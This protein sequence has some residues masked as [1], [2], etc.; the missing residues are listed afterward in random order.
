MR[1]ARRAVNQGPFRAP[2]HRR[3]VVCSTTAGRSEDRRARRLLQDP[4]EPRTGIASP[5]AMPVVGLFR[6]GACNATRRRVRSADSGSIERRVEPQH[7]HDGGHLLLASLDEVDG[8]AD[9]GVPLLLELPD[10]ELAV[11]PVATPAVP[12]ELDPR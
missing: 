7:A 5:H 1:Q 8:E 12:R 3:L 11:D 6:P 4:K 2:G 10:P 9:D